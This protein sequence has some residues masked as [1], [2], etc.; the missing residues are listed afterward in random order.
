MARNNPSSSSAHTSVP[1]TLD[2]ALGPL[3]QKAV[4]DSKD[5]LNTKFLTEARNIS[6]GLATMLIGPNDKQ[7]QAV[8][9]L[10]AEAN[11]GFG[12]LQQLVSLAGALMT[13]A[14]ARDAAEAAAKAATLKLEGAR[15]KLHEA[16]SSFSNLARAKLGAQSAALGKFGIKS[17]GGRK[18]VKRTSKKGAAGSNSSG[19]ASNDSGSTP[20][21]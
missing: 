21:S 9:D 1:K 19:S 18:G 15:A 4:D 20:K 7:D 11:V 8:L 13:S 16:S 2:D 10:L 14:A 5:A 6:V 12:D 17:I 3:T